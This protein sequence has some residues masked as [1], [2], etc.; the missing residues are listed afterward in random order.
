MKWIIGMKV[1]EWGTGMIDEVIDVDP[2]Y[3]PPRWVKLRTEG[4]EEDIVT[5]H[6]TKTWDIIK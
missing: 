3:N 6:N 5:D 4:G 2:H 1:S